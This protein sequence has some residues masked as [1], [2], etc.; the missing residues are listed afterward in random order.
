MSIPEAK[1]VGIV[2]EKEIIVSTLTIAAAIGCES[3]GAVIYRG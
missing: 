3:R 2:L 1:I